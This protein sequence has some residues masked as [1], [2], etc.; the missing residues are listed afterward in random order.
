MAAIVIVAC[1][2]SSVSAGVVYYTRKND[3]DDVS[4][5]PT[6]TPTPP[7]PASTPPSPASTPTPP[8]PAST[9]T[10]PNPFRIPDG[11]YRF[12][13][14]AAWQGPWCK[15][16]EEGDVNECW[17]DRGESI[18]VKREDDDSYSL[19]ITNGKRCGMF[20]DNRYEFSCRT[21]NHWRDH[22]SRMPG[23]FFLNGDLRNAVR[24][25]DDKPIFTA[26][27]VYKDGSKYEKDLGEFK[28][29]QWDPI[30]WPTQT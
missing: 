28:I 20:G 4:L 11:K 9:S 19:T 7:S 13:Q 18:S 8:S 25:S 21:E 24:G 15:F 29:K 2:C 12:S 6:P 30:G 22:G 17:G 27:L 14:G 1:L 23:K 5:D 26:N 10:P 3:T 16:M